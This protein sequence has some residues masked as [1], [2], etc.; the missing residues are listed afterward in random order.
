MALDE[1]TEA[2]SRPAWYRDALCKDHPE[3]EWFPA[4]GESSV[5]AMLI[6]GRC[7]V[8]DDCLHYALEMGPTLEGIWAGTSKRGRQHLQQGPS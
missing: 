3:V 8:R 6:C 4:P 1:L 5:A 2:L 7:P